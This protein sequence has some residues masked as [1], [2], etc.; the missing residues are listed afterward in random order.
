MTPNMSDIAGSVVAIERAAPIDHPADVR[1]GGMEGMGPGA[2]LFG[3]RARTVDIRGY[4]LADVILYGGLM[5]LLKDGRGVSETRYLVHDREWDD[6][7]AAPP[8]AVASPDTDGVRVVI[9]AN[10]NASN[11]YHWIVQALPA[12]DH[13]LRIRSELPLVLALPE[14]GTR[15]HDD[16]LRML[17]LADAR[18]LRI[19][20]YEPY[21]LPHARYTDFVCGST[22]F[23]V[24]LAARQTY[25]RLAASVRDMP[26]GHDAIYVSRTGSTQRPM[27]NEAA[28]ISLM[29]RRNVTVVHPEH[30]TLAQQINLFRNARVVI[31]PHGSGLTNI[32]FCKPETEVYEL[33]LQGYPNACFS[34][35]A[36]GN[37]LRYACDLFPTIEQSGDV[38]SIKW[39]A[40]LD[41]IDQRLSEMPALKEARRWA[42]PAIGA[43]QPR[44]EPAAAREPAGRLGI[45]VATYNR[46]QAVLRTLDRIREMTGCPHELIVA[47]DGSTDDTLD[48][49]RE[50][51]A[52][53]VTGTNMGVA[54]NKN[55]ALFHLA[56]VKACDVVIILEDDT[57][58]CERDWQDRWI[59][60]AMRWGHANI[61]GEW[62]R[63]SFAGGSGTADDPFLSKDVSGQ[64]SVFTRA[65]LSFGGF[66]DPRFRGYG[67][68]HV[69]HSWRL[70]RYGYG[71]VMNKAGKDMSPLFKLI[72]G[73]LEIE[74]GQSTGSAEQVD[75]NRQLC[76]R[77]MWEDHY[78]APWSNEAEMTQFRS[79]LAS[80]QPPTLAGRVEFFAVLG[81]TPAPAGRSAS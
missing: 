44:L 22:A 57:R 70:A 45:G 24:S 13:S 43:A 61:A 26:T 75:A 62:F 29:R 74:H 39:E 12:I 11:Y 4:D 18:L 34:V 28:L 19:K 38:H 3:P 32:A 77:I 54:W 20:P 1:L 50:A 8:E 65:C 14:G 69:E 59:A 36:Q 5:M 66:M 30:L 40:A 49:L 6:I 31:G 68:E 10:R 81:G 37:G 17:G 73:G 60:G 25:G 53:F 80:A 21:F 47:D 2:A 48:R 27:V 51:R 78:R 79:E 9:G 76:H 64:C 71:G 56:M 35:L 42:M 23:Q 41:V 33:G 72:S 46:S 55:R 15:M 63:Q 52:P 16:A 67:F 7:C 58:P